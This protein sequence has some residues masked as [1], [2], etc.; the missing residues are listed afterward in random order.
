MGDGVGL[1]QKWWR[2]RSVMV[3]LVVR[4]MVLE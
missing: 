4:K 1:G 2:W 3:I